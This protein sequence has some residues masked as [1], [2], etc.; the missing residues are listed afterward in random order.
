MTLRN[1]SLYHNSD[2]CKFIKQ[3]IQHGYHLLERKGG[4]RLFCN[5]MKIPVSLRWDTVK[6]IILPYV[7]LDPIAHH[8]IADFSW[9]SNTDTGPAGLSAFVNQHE[10]Q[11]VDRLSEGIK[12]N[13]FITLENAGNFGKLKWS[14]QNDMVATIWRI[15][16]RIHGPWKWVFLNRQSFPAFGSPSVNQFSTLF[17]SH[18]R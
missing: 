8:G 2:L 1:R 14:H 3:T 18:A 4:R 12:F 6:A 17:G 7:S 15:K 10:T 13:E 16:K 9:N 5:Q 11:A